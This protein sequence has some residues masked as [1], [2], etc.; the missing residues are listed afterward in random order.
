MATYGL[1][2]SARLAQN[3]NYP[4]NLLRCYPKKKVFI[5]PSIHP[6]WQVYELGVQESKPAGGRRGL[7]LLGHP[8]KKKKKSTFAPWTHHQANKHSESW[9]N[10]FVSYLRVTTNFVCGWKLHLIVN[11]EFTTLHLHRKLS[12]VIW[13]ECMLKKFPNEGLIKMMNRIFLISMRNCSMILSCD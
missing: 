3:S 1:Y 11:I 12:Q 9:K 7:L 4:L 2:Q 6:L 10:V 5:Y 8:K 13:S